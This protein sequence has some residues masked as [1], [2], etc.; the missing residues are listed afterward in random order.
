MYLQKLPAYKEKL[1]MNSSDEKDQT[2]MNQNDEKDKF[3]EEQNRGSGDEGL[4]SVIMDYENGIGIFMLSVFLCFTVTLG[5]SCKNRVFHKMR[6]ARK[7]K[8]NL[9]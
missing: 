9:I 5:K 8:L 2:E 4:T 1:Q 7:I 6:V 3:L